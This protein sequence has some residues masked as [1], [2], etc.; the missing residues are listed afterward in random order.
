M[1]GCM[2]VWIATALNA[3]HYECTQHPGERAPSLCKRSCLKA[4]FTMPHIFWCH[5]FFFKCDR[6]VNTTANQ[7]NQLSVK[8]ACLKERCTR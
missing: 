2:D 4:A 3:K 5:T 7:Y 1:Y 6:W 8:H